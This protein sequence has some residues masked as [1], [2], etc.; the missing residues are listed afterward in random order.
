MNKRKILLAAV[1]TA[2]GVMVGCGNSTGNTESSAAD[3]TEAVSGDE[4]IVNVTDIDVDEALNFDASKYVKLGDYENLAVNRIIAEVSDEEVKEE[5]E[6][7]VDENISYET[8]D[9]AASDGMQVTISY[10]GTIDGEEFEGG[11]DSDYSFIL[12][13]GEFLDEFE[14]GVKGLKAGET[15]TVTFTFPEDYSEEVAGKEVTFEITVNDVSKVITPEYNDELV[16]SATEYSTVEEYEASVR[17]SLLESA[18]ESSNSQMG[19]DLLTQALANASFSS[20]PEALVSA[21]YSSTYAS[22]ESYAEMFGMEMDE[23]LENFVGDSDGVLSAATDWAK[24]IILLKA[25]GDEKGID[26]DSLYE[27]Q[28]SDLATEYGYDSSDA[29]IEEYG[30][31]D[32]YVNVMREAVMQKLTETAVVTDVSEEEYYADEEEEDYYVDEE[33]TEEETEDYDAVVEPLDETE[34]VEETTEE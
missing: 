29:F 18:E 5:A 33:D 13:Q 34:A 17:A 4:E 30:K 31:F 10:V 27:S 22:Y 1:F 8:V 19:E 14:A 11:S 3:E 2:M 16:A 23:F 25:I 20:Y 7:L 9:E 28:V 24:E 12:G 26:F 21:C 32:V 15:N 6:A